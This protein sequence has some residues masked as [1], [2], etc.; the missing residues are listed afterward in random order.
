MLPG[1]I[2]SVET[3]DINN[4]LGTKKKK[5][6]KTK[7]HVHQPGVIMDNAFFVY[8]FFV[9]SKNNR[10]P[11]NLI[12]C[13]LRNVECRNGLT[14]SLICGRWLNVCSS[15]SVTVGFTVTHRLLQEFF[16]SPNGALG[17]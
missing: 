16:F 15:L 11:S 9:C 14:F 1:L 8:A 13:D 10:T 2:R 5:N 4:N 17:V 3:W 6:K 12:S 7:A